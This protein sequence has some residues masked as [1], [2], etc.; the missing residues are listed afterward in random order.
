MTNDKKEIVNNIAHTTLDGLAIIGLIVLI[1]LD[2][3]D[4]QLGLVMIALIV[5]I[6]G[7]MQSGTAKQ[8]PS[9]LIAGMGIQAF[10]LIRRMKGF[11]L[12][13]ALVGTM[14]SSQGCAAVQIIDNVNSILEVD[15]ATV[16]LGQG[17]NR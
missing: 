16:E 11:V 10:E 9:G 3:I 12:P 17:N 8:P 4:K 5:G 1:C 14:W 13:V 7:K 15:R 6:W 2:K